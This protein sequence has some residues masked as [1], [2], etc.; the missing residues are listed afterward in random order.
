MSKIK[1]LIFHVDQKEMHDLCWNI[2]I[3]SE[4][5]MKNGEFISK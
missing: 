3:T 1:N 2:V 4:K 5:N